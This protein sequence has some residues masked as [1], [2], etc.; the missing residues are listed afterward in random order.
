MA[1]AADSCAIAVHDGIALPGVGAIKPSDARGAFI[2]C[3]LIVDLRDSCCKRGAAVSKDDVSLLS[4]VSPHDSLS[5]CITEAGREPL[6]SRDE[7]IELAQAMDKAREAGDA[8][9]ENGHHRAEDVDRLKALIE[10][11]DQARGHMVRANM[12]LVV[13]IAKRYRGRGV[14]FLDLIQEGT[15]GLMKAVDKFDLAE[16]C[17]FST[18]ATWWIRQSVS[19][20]T[21]KHSRSIRVPAHRHH[22]IARLN[23][24]AMALEQELGRRPTAQEVA[25]RM[26]DTTV[27]KVEELM[28][29]SRRV[30]TMCLDTSPWDNPEFE[31]LGEIIPD[32]APA[33]DKIAE[34]GLMQE[35]V[36]AALDTLKPREARIVRLRYGIGGVRPHTLEEVG[37][38]FGLTRERI[39]QIEAQALKRLRHPARSRELTDLVG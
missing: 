18:Y 16:G 2:I 27:A 34:D 20:Y 19:R 14:P 12:R 38:K 33:P 11:G 39:R 13:S 24:Q 10:K 25:E 23:K 37:N 36:H 8:L 28:R 29:I 35:R 21:V 31:S 4:E 7:E 5:L 26:G 1:G 17:R 9:R 6:L 22:Q 3:Y 15:L 32:T 30:T